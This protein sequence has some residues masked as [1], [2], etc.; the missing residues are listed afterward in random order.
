MLNII[1]IIAYIPASQ[2]YS[3][4]LAKFFSEGF[5][6]FPDLLACLEASVINLSHAKCDRIYR[7]QRS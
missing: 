5:P 1:L 4:V 7:F 6:L 3:R 2:P